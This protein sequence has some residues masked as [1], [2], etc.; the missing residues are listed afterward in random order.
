[1][2][3]DGGRGE[4]DVEKRE[5]KG[6]PREALGKGWNRG[7]EEKRE[8]EKERKRERERKKTVDV[9]SMIKKN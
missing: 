7:K 5:V 3:S 8:R 2:E 6:K 9:K 4:R 1:M